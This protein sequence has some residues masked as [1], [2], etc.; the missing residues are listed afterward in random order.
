[1]VTNNSKIRDFETYIIITNFLQRVDTLSKIESKLGKDIYSLEYYEDFV[2]YLQNEKGLLIGLN[3]PEVAKAAGDLDYEVIHGY[4]ENLE[5]VYK[6][7]ILKYL[8]Y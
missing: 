8:E 7:K 5:V 6:Q 3:V 4:I 2:K 1:M